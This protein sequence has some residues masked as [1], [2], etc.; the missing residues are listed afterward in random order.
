MSHP[1][2]L[3]SPFPQIHSDGT[4]I[5]GFQIS[6]AKFCAG[7]CP[8]HVCRMYESS[9]L[10]PFIQ[11]HTCP[12]GFTVAVAEIAGEIV[13][14]SG[15]VET[16]SSTASPAFKKQN[17]ERK[18]K[19]P[20]FEQW[21]RAVQTQI[22]EYEKDLDE[23]GKNAV[24][25]LHDIKSIIGTILKTSEEWIWEQP[26]ESLSEKVE[27]GPL[28]LKTIWNSCTIL[29]SLL[30]FTDLVANPASA[31]F[32]VPRAN[33]I[34]KLVHL[35]L[36]AFEA[37]AG[38]RNVELSLVGYSYNQPRVYGSFLVLI[39]VLLDN[40]IKYAESASRVTIVVED[41]PN[42]AVYLEIAS[43]GEMVPADQRNRI[44]ERRF[45]GRNAR[46]EG[47]GHGLFIA[48][49]VAKANG[50]TIAYT[51]EPRA[52]GS[53]RG[54]NTFSFVIPANAPEERPTAP[55]E[56][57]IGFVKDTARTVARWRE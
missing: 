54:T 23:R 49:S 36:K 51:A 9:P 52:L 34:H 45:R 37:K 35:L 20:E 6:Q 7:K 28:Q 39:V 1:L 17:K 3:I 15:V 27:R 29:S 19:A 25:A 56:V 14:V 30:Q 53:S 40:A 31:S 43:V 55:V 13:R 21:V 41:R 44:F 5:D 22:P 11:Y 57:K 48:Q 18:L 32:G 33:P 24:A 4:L 46:A 38:Q 8:D 50:F 12:Y 26:G 16:A 2:T 47:T 42:G 10:R